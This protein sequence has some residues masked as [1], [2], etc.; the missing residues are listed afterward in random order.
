MRGELMSRPSG[1]EY[2]RV[3]YLLANVYPGIGSRPAYWAGIGSRP[4]YWAGVKWRYCYQSVFD[5][6]VNKEP[7]DEG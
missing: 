5:T 1:D 3:F 6:E 2:T 4:A 7:E